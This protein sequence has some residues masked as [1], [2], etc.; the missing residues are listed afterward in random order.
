MT[1]TSEPL[2]RQI[3]ETI[4]NE[5]STG[6]YQ[7][8]D[9][10]PSES[11]LAARFG[12]NRHTVRRGLAE[13]AE[14]R[15]LHAR[16]GAGVFVAAQPAEYPLT[17]RMRFHRNLEAT[18]RV[19]GRK[20]LRL[21]RLG[22]DDAQAEALGLTAGDPVFVMEGITTVDGVTVG[23]HWSSFPADLLPEFEAAC[24]QGLGVTQS[25]AACGVSDHQRAWTKLSAVAADGLLAG[26]LGLRRG[27]PVMRSESVNIG[28]DGVPVEYGI[29]HFA[30]D[31][32][33]L[34]VAPD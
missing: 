16:R 18:G 4:Q 14:Q 26:H 2:W 10:L 22:A 29:A 24:A 6:A 30:G 5:I 9:K 31:R 17:R 32:V 20:M 34:T 11:Q 19:P 33:T 15:L 13:L 12:V 8:G 3:A 27:D 25:L 23:H 7:P 28:P 21:E 1:D